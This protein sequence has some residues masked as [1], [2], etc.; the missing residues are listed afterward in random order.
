MKQDIIEMAKQ[1]GGKGLYLCTDPTETTIAM[2]LDFEQLEA[3]AKL[4]YDRGWM[5]GYTSC[6]NDNKTLTS[7]LIADAVEEEREAVLDLA[8]AYAKNNTD[9][10]DAIRARGEQQ[11]CDKH[12]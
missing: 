3:F 8:E 10:A 2:R 5:N 11:S 9:L 12:D 1:A 6:D 4:V 7:A